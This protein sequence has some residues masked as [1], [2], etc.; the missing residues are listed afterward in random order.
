MYSPELKYLKLVIPLTQVAPISCGPGV[1]TVG[2]G[3]GEH[4]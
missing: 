3:S 2:W 4:V 1:A